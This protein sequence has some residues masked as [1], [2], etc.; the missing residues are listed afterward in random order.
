MSMNKLFLI[1]LIFLLISGGC[2]GTQK[3]ATIELYRNP[4]VGDYYECTISPEG[5]VHRVSRE[6]ISAAP[7]QEPSFTGV[8]GTSV[9]TFE[10]IAEGEAE[11]VVYNH[12]RGGPPQKVVTYKAVVDDKLNLTLTEWERHGDGREF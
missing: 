6:Y 11:I 10:A 5:V 8:G 9:W 1:P 7:P 3:T 2:A 4:S 12:F